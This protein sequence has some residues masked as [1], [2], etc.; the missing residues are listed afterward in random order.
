MRFFVLNWAEVAKRRV[1]APGIVFS[2]EVGELLRDVRRGFEGERIDAF[3]LQRLHQAFHP[4]VVVG[5]AGAAHRPGQA[6]IAQAG[7]VAGS[8]V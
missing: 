4:G 3:D 2:D 6:G 1:Q 5:I 8:S 7:S